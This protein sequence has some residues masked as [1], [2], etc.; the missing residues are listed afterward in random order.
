MP[1]EPWADFRGIGNRLRYGYHV[2]ACA[3]VW[4]VIVNRLPSLPAA[5]ERA[6]SDTAYYD[7]PDG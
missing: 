4:G 2:V 3:T 5:T 1:D 6:R 7:R